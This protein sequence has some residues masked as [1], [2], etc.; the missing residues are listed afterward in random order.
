MPAVFD[1]E[2]LDL[3]LTAFQRQAQRQRACLEKT[4]SKDVKEQAKCQEEAQQEQPRQ[5]NSVGDD[6]DSKAPSHSSGGLERLTES[7]DADAAEDYSGAGTNDKGFLSRAFETFASR[8]GRGAEEGKLSADVTCLQRVLSPFILRRLKGEVMQE[9]PKKTNI[10]LR[11]ELDGTQK[12]LYLRE[13]RQHESDLAISLRRLTH[14][15]A[16]DEEVIPAVGDSAAQKGDAATQAQQAAATEGDS[17][18]PG[19]LLQI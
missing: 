8:G 5:A 19:K 10:V 1:A 15:F 2:S 12:T 7:G 13:V 11:C 16:G 6:A 3:A 14:A 17:K 4:K 9:L 18:E